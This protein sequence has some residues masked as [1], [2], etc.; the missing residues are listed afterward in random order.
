MSF[1]KKK[2]EEEEEEEI[3]STFVQQQTELCGLLLQQSHRTFE[4]SRFIVQ[5]HN[6]HQQNSKIHYKHQTNTKMPK[7]K[8]EKKSKKKSSSKKDEATGKL[9]KKDKERKEKKDKQKDKT[10]KKKS[11]KSSRA[12]PTEIT[13]EFAEPPS[14]HRLSIEPYAKPPRRIC[15]SAALLCRS[16]AALWLALAI[17]PSVAVRSPRTHAPCIVSARFV[18]RCAQLRVVR[19]AAL[20]SRRLARILA[21]R[22]RPCV[23]AVCGRPRLWR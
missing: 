15:C 17:A 20:A 12:S 11:N 16:H 7:D 13:V 8:E 23:R 9:E 2:K 19:R 1:F 3:D 18:L 14:E 10:E 6:T 21:A 4:T 5:T 22:R